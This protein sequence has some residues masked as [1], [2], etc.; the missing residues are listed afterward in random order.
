MPLFSL[1]S[2]VAVASAQ[3]SVLVSNF[4]GVD[5]ATRQIAAHLPSLIEEDLSGYEE[6]LVLSLKNA[7]AVSKY[8]AV[9]YMLSCPPGE[10]V[11]CTFVVGQ[12]GKARY[13]ITGRVRPLSEEDRKAREQTPKKSD[14]PDDFSFDEGAPAT[15]TPADPTKPVVL[16]EVDVSVLDVT[17]S[18][19][20]LSFVVP[21]RSDAEATFASGIGFALLGVLEGDVGQMEDIRTT[22]KPIQSKSN[23]DRDSVIRDLDAL[24]EEMGEVEGRRSEASGPRRESRPHY[25]LDEMLSKEAANRP[26]DKMGLTPREYVAW[27]NSGW[28]IDSWNELAV[29][30]AY[31]WMLRPM[32]GVGYGPVQQRYHARYAL[33]ASNLDVLEVYGFQEVN[34]GMDITLGLTG[35]YGIT[36]SLEVE[37]GGALELGSYKVEV[38]QEIYGVEKTP[39]MD[40]SY[41]NAVLRGLAGVRYV[42][43]PTADY[44]PL[45]GLCFTYLKGTTVLAHTG[46]DKG[47]LPADWPAPWWVG[48]RLLLGAETSFND[49]SGAYAQ[50]PITILL[51]G[52][53]TDVQNQVLPYL[54]GKIAPSELPR[55]GVSLQGGV[56]FKFGTDTAVKRHAMIRVTEQRTDDDDE[57]LD[58]N[59]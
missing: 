22:G 44:R 8:S 25:T 35:G 59:P 23:I 18:Q 48:T 52:H 15:A 58:D 11:G 19:E 2:V 50:I 43:F 12:A 20:L 57:E 24:N 45:V 21:Y 13:G 6:F 26:W 5:P 3:V 53:T 1:L 42:P 27:W 32:V 14:D 40:D 4:E 30:R 34:S 37:L 31:Q 46:L 29:G 54:P 9:L 28:D 51:G 49:K 38:Y 41:T 47:Y 56:Q 7:P 39:R 55:V 36:P 10:Y 17:N 16:A 33:Q